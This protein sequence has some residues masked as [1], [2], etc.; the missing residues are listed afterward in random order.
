LSASREPAH[1]GGLDVHLDRSTPSVLL[2]RVAGEIDTLTAP[3][4]EE[5]LGELLAAEPADALV[6]V[7]LAGVGFLASS[8]LAALIRAAHRAEAQGRELHLVGGSRAVTRPLQVTGSD[9]LFVLHADF[10][11]LPS[12]PNRGQARRPA[13]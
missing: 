3:M 6:A 10:G 2:L 11:T 13:D 5:A 1:A 9:R 12:A 4:L 7:E 8:G